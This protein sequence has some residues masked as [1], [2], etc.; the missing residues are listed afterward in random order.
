MKNIS[1]IFT[2]NQIPL[3]KYNSVFLPH[4]N[5][6]YEYITIFLI[7]QQENKKRLSGSNDVITILNPL[8]LLVFRSIYPIL[9][10][11]EFLF[12][13]TILYSLLLLYLTFFAIKN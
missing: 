13:S 9:V 12:A 1:C 3:L 10:N 11:E 6:V 4:Q 7:F 5:G 8:Y 2:L